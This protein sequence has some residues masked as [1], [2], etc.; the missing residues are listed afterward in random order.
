[1]MQD[2]NKLSEELRRSGQAERLKTLA[3]SA[4]GQK[5]GRMLDRTALT[6]AIRRGDGEALRAAVTRLMATEE[7]RR[8]NEEIEK[9]LRGNAHE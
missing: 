1:M 8:M 4:D 5:L 3:A 9:L 2:L 6:D 7:G